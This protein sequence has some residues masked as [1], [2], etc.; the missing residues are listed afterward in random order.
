M[1]SDWGMKYALVGDNIMFYKGFRGLNAI[2]HN[3]L[4]MPLVLWIQ[5]AGTFLPP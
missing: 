2:S 5:F 4:N 3:S 1:I